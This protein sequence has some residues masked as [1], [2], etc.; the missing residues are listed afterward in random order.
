MYI[1]LV[2]SE[3]Y[4]TYECVVGR[5]TTH[6]FLHT[7]Q[8]R[9]KVLWVK[10]R[11]SEDW[12][13]MH[14]TTYECVVQRC[15]THHWLHTQQDLNKVLWLKSRNSEDWLLRR[16]NYTR[17]LALM[18]IV[19]THNTLQ[20]PATRCTTLLCSA[21]QCN[22]LQRTAT[23]EWSPLVRQAWSLR[24][25]CSVWQCV[26]VCCRVLPCVAVCCSV[27]QCVAVCCSG[28]FWYT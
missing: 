5:R 12:L 7:K 19:G 2:A 6:Y 11:N 10:S 15:T 16:T 1:V 18:S 4:H 14:I 9:N 23:T 3:A 25:C 13:M 20:H 21:T 24:L 8:N 26:A 22:A 17:S 28:V 27:L